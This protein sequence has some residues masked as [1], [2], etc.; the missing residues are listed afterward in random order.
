[1]HT[2]MATR[3]EI[4]KYL[5]EAQ[6]IGIDEVIKLLEGTKQKSEE[7]GNAFEFLKK[8]M[9]E[10]V[11]VAAAVEIAFK[12]IE[13]GK[14]SLKNAEDVESSL[15]RVRALAGD[16][17][18]QF[19]DMQKAVEKAAQAVNVTS[20]TSASGLAALV[21]TGL[22]AK[23]AIDALVPTLQLAK[24]ANIDIAQAA[25]LV[26]KQ[27]DAFHLPASDA[28]KVVDELTQA[29]HGASGGLGAMSSAAAQLAPDAK[30]LGLSF[31]D[32]VSILGLLSS[33]GL[34]AEKSTRG[35][36]TIFQELQDP[37][38]KLRGELGTLGDYT[39][40]FDKAITALNGNTPRAHQA[41]LTLS[42]SSRT[43]VEVLGQ[44]GPEALAKFNAG[45]Q[46]TE[47]VAERAAKILD[48][49][50]KGASTRFGLAIEQIGEK[51][52]R[53]VL[54]PF[55]QELEKLAEKL[56]AFADTPK[57]KEIEA[58][59]GELA[60]KAAAAI[61]KF[62][63]NFDWDAF[64]SDG[65]DA[66]DGVSKALTELADNA[67]A[68]ASA[69]NKTFEAIGGTYHAAAAVVDGAVGQ[70]A[71]AGDVI[72]DIAQKTDAAS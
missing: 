23:N 43:L 72:V 61:D 21:S 48:D 26:G 11:S 45:L 57:F 25:E 1:M 37:T 36:R 20:Q 29:S 18:Q 32:T 5:F 28:Q 62:I 63:N 12:G 15:S 31:T 4:I 53:P 55:K 6:Q 34:D 40:D 33:K 65:T 42:G 16:A 49:N 70:L 59:V 64:L 71:K 17:A 54:E 44:A 60:T 47:G 7:A 35:L 8:H 19:G 9:A 3:D 52:A 30:A 51:L 67:T 56:N 13:F 27:L 58:K 66:L 24:I 41:L 14:E 38:S 50:L 69:I 46:Q 39:G 68:A 10:I 22:S 2:L